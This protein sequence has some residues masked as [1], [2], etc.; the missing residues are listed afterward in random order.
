MTT[1]TVFLKLPHFD[2]QICRE[3]E[4]PST[5]T[6]LKKQLDVATG[7]ELV[8]SHPR[9]KE[10]FALV[11]SV[12]QLYDGCN[13]KLIV[14]KRRLYV[15]PESEKGNAAAWKP[16]VWYPGATVEDIE[17][18]IL[19]TVLGSGVNTAQ[20]T[21]TLFAAES[22]IVS[23]SAS[24]GKEED[25]VLALSTSLPQ[26]VKVYA[27][28]AGGL[29][30]P[31]APTTYAPPSRGRE[32]SPPVATA[33]SIPP[34]VANP[35]SNPV[36][37]SSNAG[38]T[39]NLQEGGS[40]ASTAVR[41]SSRVSRIETLK[42]G[43]APLR[44]SAPD[45][46]CV[47]ILQGHTGFVL[48]LSIVGD[49][50]FTGSQDGTVMIW[51]L[52]NLQYIGTLP[53]HKSFVRCLDA[54]YTKKRL[55]SGS[56][57]KTLKVW[58]LE[59]F[60]C[61]KTL[62]GHTDE[63]YSVKVLDAIFISGS[64]DKTMRVWDLK[65]LEALLVV[66]QAHGAAIFAMQSLTPSVLMTGG[67]D[68]VIKL[69]NTV[70]RWSLLKTLLPPHYDGV[71]ALA[72]S[73]KRGKFYS[74]SRDRSIKEW[75]FFNPTTRARASGVGTQEAADALIVENKAQQ[76]HVHGDWI[77][78]CCLD[79]S[80]DMLITGGKDCCVKLWECVPSLACL[81]CYTGHKGPVTALACM[82]NYLFSASNDRT[83]RVWK[84][85]QAGDED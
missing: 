4:V 6:Q 3:L 64:E 45:E 25:Q 48:C 35:V 56:K 63:V 53:G 62:T 15:L 71:Q 27:R 33:Q 40:R 76:L 60:T 61:V 30:S 28:V 66:E 82:K 49:V 51:D 59:T 84:M 5:V 43:S 75:D 17:R 70:D 52:N 16:V 8:C 46:H 11:E 85:P 69:W 18:A 9:W 24:G 38:A 83:V 57:D 39:S 36:T 32:A 7:Q 23:G 13:I 14:P 34:P 73:G 78:S 42:E 21:L 44:N 79:P 20:K 41:A 55:V 58:S 22:G 77:T 19:Q 2:E 10:Q 47:H 80:E 12:G 72:V 31:S 54:H 1:I 50:L 68:R 74:V 29:G 81:D 26:D 65:T 67:R 37:S